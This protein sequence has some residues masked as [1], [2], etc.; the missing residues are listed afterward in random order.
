MTIAMSGNDT[1][2]LN[3]RNFVDFADGDITTLE[4]PNDIA[5]VKT[6]KNGNTIYSINQEGR[7]AVLIL[8]VLR[9]SP[10]DKFLLGLLA[11]QQ[12][13]FAGFTLIQGEFVKKIGDGKGNVSSDI[14]SLQS[15]IF[16]KIPSAKSNQSGD[17]DQS[18]STYTITFGN[19]PR[20]IG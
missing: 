1:L 10:D 3:L 20:T 4:F 11:N 9:G 2:Q 18:T 8:K 14:Y 13:D 6:G 12:N 17:T 16:T 15:G 5:G 7:N 19:A